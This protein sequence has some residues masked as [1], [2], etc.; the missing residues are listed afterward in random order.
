MVGLTE[1]VREGTVI[2]EERVLGGGAGPSK[3]VESRPILGRVYG[4]R[5]VEL[6]TCLSPCTA[7]LRS[8]QIADVSL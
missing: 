3:A 2:K 8:K 6:C 5:G 4:E 7:F 1:V